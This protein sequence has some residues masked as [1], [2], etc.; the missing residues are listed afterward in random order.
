ME[1]L[2]TNINHILKVQKICNQALKLL[3]NKSLRFR[4]MRRK[5][6]H[7]HKTKLCN[8]QNKFKNWSYYYRY[9][10]SEKKRT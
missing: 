4:P 5:K 6:K 10:Y 9:F 3:G 8:W 2:D 7:K 1:L